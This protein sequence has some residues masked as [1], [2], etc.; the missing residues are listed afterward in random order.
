MSKLTP[1][2]L[3]LIIILVVIVPVS[4]TGQT[5]ELDYSIVSSGGGSAASGSYAVESIVTIIGTEAETQ[6][7]ASYSLESPLAEA[8]PP[9]AVDDWMFY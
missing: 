6:S 9:A 4:L 7:S 2:S 8:E 5:Y 3:S 1:L